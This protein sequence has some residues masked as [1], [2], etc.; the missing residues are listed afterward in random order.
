MVCA[1]NFMGVVKAKEVEK[2]L[3]LYDAASVFYKF[4]ID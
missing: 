2:I 3:S 1:K 4:I